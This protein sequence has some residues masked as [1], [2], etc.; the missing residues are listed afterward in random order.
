MPLVYISG[1]TINQGKDSCGYYY[2]FT[3][4]E[5]EG[6]CFWC[7]GDLPIGKRG[8]AIRRALN[9]I[10]SGLLKQSG[11]RCRHCGLLPD[12]RG[13]HRHHI[14]FRGRGGQCTTLNVQLWCVPCHFGPCGHRTEMPHGNKCKCG[15]EVV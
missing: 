8:Q 15:K 4:Y 1:R 10:T 7:G 14:Y 5:G 13:L 9:E 2:T 11:G 6:I 12:W 3:S